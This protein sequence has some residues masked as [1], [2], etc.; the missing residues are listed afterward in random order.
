MH[1]I[2]IC[3]C[4]NN[5]HYLLTIIICWESLFVDN[6]YRVYLLFLTELSLSLYIYLILSTMRTNTILRFSIVKIKKSRFSIVKIKKS[7][8][9]VI[10][11][12]L[13][14]SFF[15]LKS[16][17]CFLPADTM[18]LMPKDYLASLCFI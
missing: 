13:F 18:N 1:I 5:N 2:Y 17:F 8:F 12:Y 4:L 9:S 11:F 6:H 15:Y 16:F 10:F 14:V 7:R 3:D